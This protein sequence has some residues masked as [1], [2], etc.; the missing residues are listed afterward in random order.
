MLFKLRYQIKTHFRRCIHIRICIKYTN[1]YPLVTIWDQA[2]NLFPRIILLLKCLST[3]KR[4]LF[5]K[6]PWFEVSGSN[7][8]PNEGL[9][10]EVW[11]FICLGRIITMRYWYVKAKPTHF[12]TRDGPAQN[13]DRS[14]GNQE[15]EYMNLD[16]R[17]V[18]LDFRQADLDFQQVQARF[19]TGQQKFGPMVKIGKPWYIINVV[20]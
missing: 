12:W 19:L 13:W 5:Q 3:L 18:G 9:K 6:W 10:A 20:W 1:I 16:F 4:L 2:F 17:E 11:P 8:Q 15:C 14:A 7:Y